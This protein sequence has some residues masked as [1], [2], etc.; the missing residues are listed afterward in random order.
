MLA[1]LE[2]RTYWCISRQRVWGMPVPVFYESQSR[3]PLISRYWSIQSIIFFY[4]FTLLKGS[5]IILIVLIKISCFCVYMCSSLKCMFSDSYKPCSFETISCL[6]CCRAS[7]DHLKELV[8]KKGSDCWWS[9]SLKDLLPDS[10]ITAV[11]AVS[12]IWC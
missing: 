4:E 9:M 10:V 5:G 6:V 8:A 3:K 2:R 7:I 11:T 1:Q 12:S